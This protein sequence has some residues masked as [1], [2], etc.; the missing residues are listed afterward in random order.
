MHNS[1][2]Q[3]GKLVLLPN[4]DHSSQNSFPAAIMLPSPSPQNS[5]QAL[6]ATIAKAVSPGTQIRHNDNG[7]P[8]DVEVRSGLGK[9]EREDSG[10]QGELQAK[11]RRKEEDKKRLEEEKK[12]LDQEIKVL[13]EALEIV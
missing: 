3:D 12:R 7:S 5:P 2:E 6:T 10:Y 13:R 8:F 1:D 4:Q 11:L 9:R